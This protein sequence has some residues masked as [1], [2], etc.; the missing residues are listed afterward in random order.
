MRV[1]ASL[2]IFTKTPRVDQSTAENSP[3]QIHF[4]PVFTVCFKNY[5]VQLFF[6]IMNLSL[7]MKLH[8]FWFFLH[9]CTLKT[10]KS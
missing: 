8:I 10:G 1:T 4:T 7:K 6:G 2:Q 3:R 9:I 5:R